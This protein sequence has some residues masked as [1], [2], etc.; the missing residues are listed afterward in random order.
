MGKCYIYED[1]TEHEGDFCVNIWINLPISDLVIGD[2]VFTAVSG[3]GITGITADRIEV[4]YTEDPL[5]TVCCVHIDVPDEVVG[6]FRV[7]L[8]DR[9]YLRD[10]TRSNYYDWDHIVHIPE[11][12]GEMLDVTDTGLFLYDTR[13]A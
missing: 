10:N 4:E 12:E 8:Q 6:T 7:G 13:G 11:S 1:G 2:V 3:N 5:Y 9:R